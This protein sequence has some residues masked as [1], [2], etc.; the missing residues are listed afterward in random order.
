MQR[1]QIRLDG[2][3]QLQLSHGIGVAAEADQRGAEIVAG[4]D[5][6]RL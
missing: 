5:I 4:L 6:I 2:K 3:R 1:R